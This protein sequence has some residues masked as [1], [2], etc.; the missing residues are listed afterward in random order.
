MGS[1][2]LAHDI[3]TTG[4]KATLFRGDGSLV[5]SASAAYP[6]HYPR[7][8]WAEQDPGDYWN[9]FCRASRDL[10]ASSGCRAADVGVVSFSGQMMAALAIDR[11]GR[12]LRPSIIWADQRASREAEELGS[13]LS[14]GRV[15]DLTGHPLSASYSLEK[16]MWIRRNEPDVFARTSHF[17][18]AKDYLVRALT[19]RVCSDYS[20]AS[21]MQALDIRTLQWSQEI[22]DAAGISKGVLPELME[23][24]SI[25]GTITKAA[26]DACGLLQGTPVAVGAG[27]GACATC[28]AGVVTEGDAY[29]CLGTSTWMAT[30][31][32]APLPDPQRRTFTFC[33][34]T[35]GL[36]FPC[37]TMQ[38]GGGSLT[39]FRD[40]LAD[41]EVAEAKRQGTDVHDLLNREAEG[42][43]PGSEGLLFLPY[44]MGERS[45][46]WNSDARACFVGLSMRHGK[47]HML[48]AVMEGVAYNMRVIADVFGELG[49]PFSSVRM[50]GGAARSGTW[51]QVFADV[52]ERPMSLSNFVEES[53]SIGAAI[54]GG[55]GIGL[56]SS[57]DEAARIVR[58]VEQ[59][60]P[61]PGALPDLPRSLLLLH[62]GVQ[63]AGAC[64]HDAC[65]LP[66]ERRRAAVKPSR[67]VP[68]PPEA[69][70]GSCPPSCPC[71]MVS[72]AGLKA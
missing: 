28:G 3:G 37:G 36:Y 49:K 20:D 16:I 72:T 61:R 38:T 48:R 58:D 64:F 8:G 59:T 45:P 10:L 13:R 30:A 60:L 42:V 69:A 52:L 15:Y 1:L 12:P 44:L 29:I 4:D 68:Y 5:A 27:D 26:A 19:G 57:I 65:R 21:G 32:R 34:F 9:A 63:A 18:N 43:P 40:T 39:W 46:W 22:L 53:T 66:A 7:P 55:V 2:I 67:A 71:P 11:E 33:H 14:A 25:A 23:S 47:S 35:R 31:S 17:I 41:A 51:R 62:E 24:T 6:V 54:A 56:F 50:I 70:P